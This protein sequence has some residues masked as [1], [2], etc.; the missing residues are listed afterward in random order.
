LFE[1]RKISNG[2]SRAVWN[3]NFI[4]LIS[5]ASRPKRAI[6]VSLVLSTEDLGENCIN[7]R[8]S[9]SANIAIFI[10][11]HEGAPPD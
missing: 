7:H 8:I 10:S 5:F 2:S 4:S 3:C 9:I 1:R 11:P 6:N